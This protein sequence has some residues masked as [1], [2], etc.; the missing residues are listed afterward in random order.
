MDREPRILCVFNGGHI[1]E[2]PDGTRE[3]HGIDDGWRKLDDGT[4]YEIVDF[5]MPEMRRIWETV[6]RMT[7]AVRRE[8]KNYILAEVKSDQP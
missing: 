3:W 5:A 2:L 7:P 8:L 4:V 1:I 6:R